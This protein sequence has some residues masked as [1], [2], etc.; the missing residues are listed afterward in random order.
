MKR[1]IAAALVAVT[2]MFTAAMFAPSGA[3]ATDPITRLQFQVRVLQHKVG[4]L[5]TQVANL[6]A[7]VRSLNCDVYGAEF[8][9]NTDPVTFSDGTVGYPL[10]LDLTKE[11]NC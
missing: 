8:Y 10:Y 11:A 5:N 9:D 7:D 4:T 6:R 1:L 2:V 3:S